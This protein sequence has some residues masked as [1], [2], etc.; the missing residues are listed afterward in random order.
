MK[1][2]LIIRNFGPIKD[3]E[4]ELGRFNI[5][6]GEQATGKSTVAKV[7]AVC[8]YF[9]Y[10]L[11]IH[12]WEEL[13]TSGLLDW[14]LFDFIIPKETYISYRCEHYFFEAKSINIEEP[15]SYKNNDI[16]FGIVLT[17]GS[18]V[19]NLVPISNSFKK[20]LEAVPN[21]K[22][23]DGTEYDNISSE[24]GIPTSFYQ[25]EVASVLDNPF[26]FPVE[27]GLQSIFSLGR[28]SVQ[29]ISDTLFNQFA[30]LDQSARF[31]K[32]ETAIEP[33]NI[34]Y[35][36]E[37]GQGLIKSDKHDFVKSFQCSKWLSIYNP[38]CTNN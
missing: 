22:P 25:N 13:F 18:I 36:N 38:C 9:T 8:R 35:K 34:I 20:L 17:S 4:L 29:N 31:F 3:V 28:S 24:F 10:I 19:V 30:K 14:G 21:V 5:L 27:R 12:P 2:K 11:K 23:K 6:I 1:E 15:I 7:L 33:L 37:N 32:T 16:N 26:Y